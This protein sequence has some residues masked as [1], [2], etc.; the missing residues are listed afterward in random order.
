MFAMCVGYSALVIHCQV[1]QSM[2]EWWMYVTN[3]RL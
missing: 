3:L 1:N 2:Q